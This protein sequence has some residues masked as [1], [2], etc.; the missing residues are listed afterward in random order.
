MF[1]VYRSLTPIDINDPPEPIAVDLVGTSFVDSDVVLGDRFYYR[2]SAT[3]NGIEKFSDEV[4]GIAG[5]IDEY[6][7]NVQLLIFA[8]ADTFP[9]VAFFDSSSFARTV[10][11]AGS[12][13]IVSPSVFPP[14]FDQGSIHIPASGG[15]VNSNLPSFGVE[16]LTIECHAALSSTQGG[17]RTLWQ[18]GTASGSVKISTD[19]SRGLWL[20][21]FVVYQYVGLIIGGAMVLNQWHHVCLMRKNGIFYLFIDGVRIGTNADYTTANIP[22][23]AFSIGNVP[24]SLSTVTSW[25]GFVSGM[26]ITKGIAR[27]NISGFTPPSAKYPN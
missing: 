6:F 14:K 10:T 11:Y 23:A 26:R 16:D 5:E 8:D 18:F 27:Y 3:K 20:E 2:V 9:S 12:A 21:S 7:A 4:L 24:G 22:A 13:Q 19:S 17:N 15:R 25:D 1:K